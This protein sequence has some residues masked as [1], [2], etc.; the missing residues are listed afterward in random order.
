MGFIFGGAGRRSGG[1]QPAEKVA[2]F[3]DDIRWYSDQVPRQPLPG[4]ADQS[5]RRAGAR[6]GA[7]FFWWEHWWKADASGPVRRVMDDPA[8]A[9]LRGM[10]RLRRHPPAVPD[11]NG[12]GTKPFEITVSSTLQFPSGFLPKAVGLAG[13]SN[14]ATA[15]GL[16][17]SKLKSSTRHF[18]S[19]SLSCW[20]PSATHFAS[21]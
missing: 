16:A 4:G 17:G 15:S 14:V 7:Q 10:E 19:G 11:G 21:S 18:A 13:I 12:Q 2:R 3:P 6:S 9:T 20:M 1:F 5:H 8:V